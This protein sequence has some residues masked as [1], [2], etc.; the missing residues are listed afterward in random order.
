MQQLRSVLSLA[1]V[2]LARPFGLLISLI[3]SGASTAET[4][5]GS[6]LFET[7]MFP[8]DWKAFAGNHRNLQTCAFSCSID[9]PL[10]GWLAI[11]QE[12][13][14]YQYQ[15]FCCCLDFLSFKK[16]RGAEQLHSTSRFVS[17]LFGLFSL[18]I[19]R[20]HSSV[21]GEDPQLV[22]GCVKPIGQQ[23]EA[24]FIYI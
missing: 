9:L 19:F 23:I 15:C 17:L 16:F 4:Q 20:S 13:H 21:Q 3:V 2:G 5:Q 18:L 6:S 7:D 10:F 12:S 8:Q 22:S 24:P 1:A 14:Q 11:F